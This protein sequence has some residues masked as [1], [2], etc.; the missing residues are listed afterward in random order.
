METDFATRPAALVTSMQYRVQFKGWPGPNPLDFLAGVRF[1]FIRAIL[2]RQKQS[3]RK[4]ISRDKP[5]M[6]AERWKKIEELYQAAV[7]LSAEKRADHL[8]QACPG[9]PDLRAEVLS[10]LAQNA[11]SFLESAPLSAVKPLINKR[12]GEAR[13]FRDCGADRPRRHERSLPHARYTIEA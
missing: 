2:F 3:A 5:R 10:L 6:Q 11:D 12:R 13:Q 4:R 7:A 9:D 1:A 8:A